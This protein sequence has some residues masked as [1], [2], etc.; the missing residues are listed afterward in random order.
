MDGDARVTVAHRL[1]LKPFWELPV[2]MAKTL[3]R[4]ESRQRRAPL[5]RE[6]GHWGQIRSMVRRVECGAGGAGAHTASC[7]V[8]RPAD[9]VRMAG[10]LTGGSVTVGVWARFAPPTAAPEE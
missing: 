6:L 3:P 10:D 9:L 4:L 2:R 5:G 7:I 8:D 1:S